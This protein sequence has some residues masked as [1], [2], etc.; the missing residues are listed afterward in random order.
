M[1]QIFLDRGTTVVKEVCRPLLNDYSVLVEVKYSCISSGTELATIS[2]TG[3]AALFGNIPEKVKKIMSSLV[4]HGVDG[5]VALIKSKLQGEFQSLGYACSGMVIAVGKKVKRLKTGDFVACAG[6]GYAHHADIVCVPEHLVVKIYNEQKLKEASI[7]TLGAIALQGLRRAQVQI[8]ESVCVI[9]LGLLGQLTI[10]LAKQAGCTVIGVDIL[11]DRLALAKKNGA[12]I[13]YDSMNEDIQ[14][15]IA[16]V[17]N[18]QGV[19]AS[20]ITASSHSDDLMQQAIEV[21]RKKGKVVIVGDVGLG[22]KRDPLYAKEIDVLISCSYGPGRYDVQYEQNSNDYPYGYVRWTEHRNMQ[23]FMRLVEAEKIDVLSLLT[24]QVSLHE[25][26]TAY[27]SIKDRTAVGV[28]LCYEEG[29]APEPLPENTKINKQESMRFKPAKRDNLR[30]G[31]VGAGGFAKVMLMPI[32]SQLPGVQINA[33]VDANT[34]RSLTLSRLYG[35]AKSLVDDISLFKEDLVDVVVIASP[36]KYHCEQAMHAL[37]NGKAV[38]LEKPMVTD[39]HQLDILM[40]YLKEHDQV[41]F[42]VDYNRSFSPFIQKIKQAISKR[43][44]PLVIQYRMN[45]GFIPKDHW[46]KTD[47]GAGRVI[48]E[49]CHVFD[50]FYE[51]TQAKPISISAESMIT[52]NEHLFPTD[53][54]VTTINFSDGS[55]CSLVYT[56]VG[57]EA[58]GKERMEIF[59][60]SKS[61]VLDDYKELIGYGLPRSFNSKQ[62]FPDKGHHA[63]MQQ[64]F[65]ELR[66]PVFTPPISLQRLEDVARLTLLIDNLVCDGGGNKVMQNTTL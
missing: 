34:S 57:H 49:A 54:F 26:S 9:G 60:D 18:H 24:K 45:A 41:P 42:C 40:K 61:I 36:H 29:K 33:V 62:R 31:V 32:I 20:L 64:F 48:G 2:A 14:R 12:D 50:L 25:L 27:S 8:G 15:E 21:T 13:V 63:L 66:S 3:K 51:L 56:S 10:Q 22:L 5:T 35:A 65:T 17:T 7:T 52:Q 30:V 16:Y 39:V 19:D 4:S 23:A 6:A 38:F 55:L 1:R 53:N 47:V 11:P 46:V 59:F 37:Q 58:L 43:N 28:L 44:S